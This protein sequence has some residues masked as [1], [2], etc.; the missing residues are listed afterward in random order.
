ME[1]DPNNPKR[2]RENMLATSLVILV[3]GIM[4]FYLYIISLGIIG[5]MLAV[6]IG[7][8]ILGA[9]HYL[10]WGR[11]FSEEIAAEREAVLRQEALQQDAPRTPVAKDAIQDLSH[12][13]G[14][15]K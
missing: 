2:S 12:K 9:M 5:N 11:S 8:A 10:V 4:L 15:E 1:R 6:A 7:I 3:G 14:I 13:H